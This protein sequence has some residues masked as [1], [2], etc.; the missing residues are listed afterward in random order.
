MAQPPFNPTG[1]LR[2]DLGQG[3]ITLG[4]RASRVLVPLDAL[5]SLCQHA[6]GEAVSD[7]GRKLG[8][9]IGRRLVERLGDGRDATVSVIDRSAGTVRYLV[10]SAATAERVRGWLKDGAQ[11]GEALGRLNAS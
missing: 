7:F 11:Y 3:T 4:G 6:E 1:E 9:E 2:F 8:A 5:V 10:S